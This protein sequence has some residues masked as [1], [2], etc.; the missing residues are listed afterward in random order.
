MMA[1]VDGSCVLV[2]KRSLEELVNLCGLLKALREV[3]LTV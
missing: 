1:A 2:L 3:C